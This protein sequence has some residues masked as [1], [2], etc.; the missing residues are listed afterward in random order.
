[1]DEQTLRLTNPPAAQVEELR[2]VLDNLLGLVRV[3]VYYNINNWYRG[4]LLLPSFKTNKAD[5]ERM[6]GVQ[7]PV[8]FVNPPALGFFDKLRKLPRLIRPMLLLM[9]SFRKMDRLVEDFF[10]NFNRVYAP[11]DRRRFHQ[12]EIGKLI[13]QTHVLN[14]TLIDRWQ[15]PII[16]DTDVMMMN[17][18]VARALEGTGLDNPALAQNL[19]MAGEVGIESTEPTKFLI[20]LCG[21]IR[22]DSG[23]REACD[24][25]GDHQLMSHVQAQAPG[26]YEQCQAYI[27]RY[28]DRTM[29]DL[30]LES[31]TLWEDPSFMFSI[32]RNFLGLEDLTIESLNA[33]ER[34]LRRDAEA[35]AFEAVEKR[36]DRRKLKQ[37]KKD[38]QRSRNAA[39]NRENTRLARTRLFGLFRVLYL[40]IGRQMAFYGILE[41]DRDVFYLTV[42]EIEAYDEGRAVQTDLKT[43][44]TGRKREYAAYEDEEPAH[45]F[46]TY[47]P[48]Y[49]HNDFAH[50]YG[51]TDVDT[52][53]PRLTGVGC[54]P[55]VVEESLRLIFS[56]KDHLDLAGQILCT[57]GWAPLCPSAGGILVERGS[58]LSHSAVVARELGIPAIVNVPGLT[59]IPRDGE[60][61]RMDGATG[62]VQRLDEGAGTARTG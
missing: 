3:R 28:G 62:V 33:S 41:T 51:L 57:V 10:G 21:D 30:K 54:Y 53:A 8:D 15:T 27:R 26:F 22:R 25:L 55:G 47:G 60:R 9:S 42:E 35:R 31:L 19:P 29:G 4:L 11:T 52:A 46:I 24:R 12:L 61:I 17:G 39:K 56:P 45:H 58:T 44:A 59:K 32:L 7:D 18:R 38:L 48:V 49:H 37:F 14:R 5:M 1:M 50:P 36:F 23:L 16:N 13:E 34:A 43:L 40:E 6:M 2:P 20:Q